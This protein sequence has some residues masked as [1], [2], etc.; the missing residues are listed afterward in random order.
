[1]MRSELAIGIHV[2]G[3]LTLFGGLALTILA[4]IGIRRS[5]SVRQLLQW[6]RFATTVDKLLPLGALLV[7]LSGLYLVFTTWGWSVGWVNIA[8]VL[9]V[10]LIPLVPAT[11]VFRFAAIRRMAATLEDGPLSASVQA[12]TRDP[13]LWT[14]A[15]IVTTGSCCILWLM[16]TKPSQP[17]ALGSLGIA[18]LIGLAGVLPA[19]TRRGATEHVA[20]S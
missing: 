12:T 18:L 19:W 17:G 15:S 2:L 10:L 5:R 16:I 3:T 6:A 20:Q 9:L 1:M 13:V 4:V 7:L 11:I 8:L 14:G